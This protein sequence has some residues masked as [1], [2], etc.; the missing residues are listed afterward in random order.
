MDGQ[1]DVNNSQIVADTGVVEAEAPTVEGVSQEAAPDTSVQAP[2]AGVQQEEAPAQSTEVLADGTQT[3]K[4]VEYSRFKEVN[5][6][7][8]AGDE[9]NAR[10]RQFIQS[11]QAAPQPQQPQQQ[12]QSISLQV[13]QELNIDPEDILTGAQQAQINDEVARRTTA[14]TQSQNQVQNFIT[15]KPDYAQ[16]VGTLDPLTNQFI[17]AQPMLRVMQANPGITQALQGA[18]SG[19]AQL[20]YQIASQDPAYMAQVAKATA[21]PVVVAS[22]KANQVLH[23][24]NS[25]TSVSAVAGTGTI[26]KAAAIRAMSPGEF[27]AYKQSIMD[28]GGVIS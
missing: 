6:A 9:E 12:P 13:M 1:T 4:P 18:G 16:V 5:D 27:D 10:L 25:M 8:N 15:S 19:A 2:D 21:D 23:N 14:V 3:D 26:D 11:Q 7:K 28:N 20:A 17:Y 24:A 22:E